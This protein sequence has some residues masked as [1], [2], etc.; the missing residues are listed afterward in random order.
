VASSNALL[1]TTLAFCFNVFAFSPATI[2]TPSVSGKVIEVG[3]EIDFYPYAFINSS[4]EPDGFSVDLIKAVAKVSGL[5]LHIRAAPWDKVWND[6]LAGRIDVVPLIGKLTERAALIDY[7]EPHTGM[8]DAF[9]V[10]EGS[11]PLT[12]LAAAQGKEIVVMRSDVAH[13]K[14]IETHFEG[15]IVPVDT[16]GDGLQLVASGK[17]DAFLGPLLIGTLA[18][19]KYDIKGLESGEPVKDYLRIHA[20]GVKK[21]DHALLDQLNQGLKL[22][23]GNG[24]YDRLYNKWLAAMND[25]PSRITDRSTGLMVLTALSVLA[26]LFAL[27]RRRETD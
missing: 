21:G 16:I 15:T 7:S 9:F 11:V 20:F 2:E 13:H 14:L 22:V 26:I 19:R 3:S 6:M 24:E 12:N 17:H 1:V 5:T 4:G 8:P 18:I 25:T 27:R 10:R 23:K